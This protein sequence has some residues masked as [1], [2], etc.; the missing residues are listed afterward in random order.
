MEVTKKYPLRECAS[1]MPL[2]F[3]NICIR[4]KSLNA[5]QI[6]SLWGKLELIICGLSWSE[7]IFPLS[8]GTPLYRTNTTT[9]NKTA[10]TDNN[11]NN[12]TPP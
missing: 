10:T 5:I 8:F 3:K 12:D 9:K 7:K 2:I 1:H 4:N 11:N 6:C